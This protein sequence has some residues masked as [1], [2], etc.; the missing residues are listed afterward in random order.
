MIRSI[1]VPHS[2]TCPQATHEMLID[3][4]IIAEMD[5]LEIGRRGWFLRASYH[6]E[7]GETKQ[8]PGWF[9][10]DGQSSSHI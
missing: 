5:F 1:R 10:P 4:R 6:A 3:V 2:D 8:P 7:D 9:L